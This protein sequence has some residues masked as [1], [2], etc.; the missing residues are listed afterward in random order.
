MMLCSFW[1]ALREAEGYL[2]FVF[3][4]QDPFNFES[5]DLKNAAQGSRQRVGLKVISGRPH[6]AIFKRRAMD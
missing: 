4:P 5:T 2:L 1:L 6:P 3:Q